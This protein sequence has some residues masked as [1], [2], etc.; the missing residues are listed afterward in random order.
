VTGY[1]RLS[2]R[3]LDVARIGFLFAVLPAACGEQESEFPLLGDLASGYAQAD[4]AALNL[5]PAEAAAPTCD[6]GPNGGVCACVDEPIVV[7]PPNVYFVLDRSGSMAEDNK[8][9]T[10]ISVIGEIVIA[11]GPRAVIGAAVFPDPYLAANQP[12]DLPT[13]CEAG[14]EVFAP[15]QGNAPAG[16]PGATALAFLSALGHI[17]ADGGTPTAA[18][19]LALEPRLRS[20]PGKTFVVLATDGGPNCDESLACGIAQCQPNIDGDCPV[21]PSSCCTDDS[22]AANQQIANLSCLD[23]QATIGAVQT[24]ANDGIPVYVVGV[25]GSEVYADLLDQLAQAGGTARAGDEAGTQYYAVSTAD[26]AA[27]TT[28]LSKVAAAITGSCTLQLNE[29]PVDPTLVNVFF[30]EQPVPQPGPDG[31]TL[32][33]ATVTILGASCQKIVDGDVLDVRVVVG[34]PTAL[35]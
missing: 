26:Q 34:C 22:S 21:A 30:D 1:R 12:V 11:L 33:G 5:Q 18:T 7:D 15:H 10:I 14:I 19:L 3:A 27:F 20:L 25:P 28:T 8:W 9:P 16:T 31:W 4:A 32:T 23:S 2:R 13:A 35:R 24:L 17:G 6:L 29:A